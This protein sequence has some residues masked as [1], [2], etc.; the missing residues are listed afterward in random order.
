MEIP[1]IEITW[2]ESNNM[3]FLQQS[4]LSAQEADDEEFNLENVM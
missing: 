3:T 2:I 1:T 4:R